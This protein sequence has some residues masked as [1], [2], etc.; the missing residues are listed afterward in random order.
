MPP[1]FGYVLA[2]YPRV[3]IAGGPGTGKS[4]L[5]AHVTDRPVIHTDD[6]AGKPW[7]EIPRSV[8]T[9]VAR[10]G[11]RWCVEGCQAARA[12]RKG[13]RPDVV[14]VLE[15][16]WVMLSP[17]QE[18]FAKGIRTILR[19]VQRETDLRFITPERPRHEAQKGDPTYDRSSYR[20]G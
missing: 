3:V 7:A 9:A 10:A 18:I 19:E 1:G 14:I 6:W 15:T 16:V 11:D 13:L 20:S 12:L 17:R 8:M 2:H 4:T 5:A